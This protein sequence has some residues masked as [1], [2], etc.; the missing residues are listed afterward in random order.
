[1]RPLYATLTDNGLPINK[2]DSDL[3]K[4]NTISK[5]KNLTQKYTGNS[6]LRLSLLAYH[7]PLI[8]TQLFM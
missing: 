5:K 3:A 7:L 4:V 6:Q 2:D 8:P 1:M